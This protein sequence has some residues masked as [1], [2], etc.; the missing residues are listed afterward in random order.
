MEWGRGS[1]VA[2]TG[3]TW[4]LRGPQFSRKSSCVARTGQIYV[5][6]ITWR[7][8]LRFNTQYPNR[9]LFIVWHQSDQCL[10]G[11]NH[12]AVNTGRNSAG[13]IN[14]G[15][16]WLYVE[17]L[18]KSSQDILCCHRWSKLFEAFEVAPGLIPWLVQDRF[19]WRCARGIS[20]AVSMTQYPITEETVYSLTFKGINACMA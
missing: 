12:Y 13:L 17:Q 3:S 18:R 5:N 7:W 1:I 4:L 11:V 15:D 20:F 16:H 14:S 8:L 10:H 9:E 2:V 19:T 6:V